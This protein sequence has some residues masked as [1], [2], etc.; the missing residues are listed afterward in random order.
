M[1]KDTCFI[2]EVPIL[3]NE[4]KI[5]AN[6]RKLYATDHAMA[7][8][9]SY[10]TN[11][12]SVRLEHAVLMVLKRISEYIF[13]YRT[14]EGYEIDFVVSDRFHTPLQLVQVTDNLEQSRDREIRA[15]TS[16][17]H[18]LQKDEGYI[19]TTYG[20]EDIQTESGTIH[21]IP[22]W[23]FSLQPPI[24]SKPKISLAE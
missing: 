13:Y 18:E 5:Q 14:A 3:G 6:P 20:E 7:V 16:A 12:R 22:A 24:I 21:V 15:M 11:S 2:H 4:K 19:V 10:F 17:M 9:F 1:I 8:I 23:K